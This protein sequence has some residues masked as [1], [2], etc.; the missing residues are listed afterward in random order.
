[1]PEGTTARLPPGPRSGD[2]AGTPA[3]GAAAGATSC[4][5]P[6]GW[7]QAHPGTSTTDT[8]GGTVGKQQESRS[9]DEVAEE[10]VASA[11]WESQWEPDEAL[12]S[13][14]VS[15]SSLE[16]ARDALACFADEGAAGAAG[17]GWDWDSQALDPTHPVDTGPT[18]ASPGGAS[19][20]QLL[21]QVDDGREVVL[22]YP[23]WAAAMVDA[24]ARGPVPLPPTLPPVADAVTP[25]PVSRA[26]ETVS[27]PEGAEAP[28]LSDG[29]REAV[30]ILALINGI[31]E[32]T[33][34]LGRLADGDY[35]GAY[36]VGQGLADSTGAAADFATPV[37]ESCALVPGAQMVS[38]G[39]DVISGIDKVWSADD[40]QAEAEGY[41]D[42]AKGTTAA[43]GGWATWAGVPGAPV[44]AA[45]AAGL[46]VGQQI[47]GA[48]QDYSRER[49]YFGGNRTYAEWGGD[50][51]RGWSDDLNDELGTE[52]V[53]E[54]LAFLPAL[55]V[56]TGAGFY[57]WGR[58]G[59]EDL[60]DLLF[61][62]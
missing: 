25:Y 53:G 2:G 15:S 54:A 61:G 21:D 31:L 51:Y 58:G 42:I 1:M 49:D 47:A 37:G 5:I 3:G 27:L 19:T 34:G 13:L 60:G 33:V 26:A 48:G 52:Y 40:T 32:T 4:D 43:A 8:P 23:Q 45:G 29:A 22:E 57:S 16:E 46:E 6:W 7:R 17:W 14:G 50:L 24:P 41:T 55:A 59:L 10:E 39:F 18:Y 28:R 11:G 44:L 35:R 20:A 9:V 38:G 12:A 30:G 62:D 36:D 56:G